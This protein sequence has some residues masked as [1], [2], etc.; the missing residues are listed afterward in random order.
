MRNLLLGL[1]AVFLLAGCLGDGAQA[2]P[3]PVATVEPTPVPTVEITPPPAPTEAPSVE[4]TPVYEETDK[5]TIIYGGFSPQFIK[6]AAGTKVTWEN[7][8]SALHSVDAVD[9]SFTSGY[10][11]GR[12]SWSYTFDTAGTFEYTD[13]TAG[14][15]TGTVVV[16]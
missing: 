8:E 5:V 1:F 15:K 4:P 13:E 2:T 3:T 6:V 12:Q 16:Q 11:A 14:G 7:Q 9:G 10:I